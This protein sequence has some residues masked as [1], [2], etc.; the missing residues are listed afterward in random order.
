MPGQWEFQIGPTGPLE[1]GDQVGSLTLGLWLRTT[2]PVA[3]SVGMRVG[4]LHRLSLPAGVFGCAALGSYPTPHPAHLPTNSCFP[5]PLPSA[6]V[7][8]ARWLLHRLG[9]EFGVISTFAP[10]PMKGDW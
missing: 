5:A 7:M 4:Q 8:I 10:K 3:L 1:T 9:E 2:E 6:Q